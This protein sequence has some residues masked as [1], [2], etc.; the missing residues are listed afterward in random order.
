VVITCLNYICTHIL[1]VSVP[2]IDIY[3][4]NIY[5][6]RVKMSNCSKKK[7]QNYLCFNNS[8]CNLLHVTC[9]QQKQTGLIQVL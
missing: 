5:V 7:E 2:Y 1:T 3:I 6:C 8:L 9:S 4:Y